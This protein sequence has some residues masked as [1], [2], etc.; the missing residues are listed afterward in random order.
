[1][2]NINDI[3]RILAPIKN[4]IY[5]IIGRAILSAVKN[6]TKTATVQVKGLDG[7]VITDM[8]YMSPYGFEAMPSEGQV[9]CIFINGNRDQGMAILLHNRE[10]RPQD[11][12]TDE[13][14]VWSKYNNFMKLNSAGEV[15]TEASSGAY[16]KEN[17]SGEVE[18]NGNVDYAVR[19]NELKIAFDQLK[20]DF[21]N[22]II[23]V[24]NLHTHQYVPGVVGLAPTAIPVPTDVP[25]TADMSPSK[26]DTVRLP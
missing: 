24:F 8:E 4:K 2:I 19:Y 3:F 18:V 20:A 15:N 7:E 11:L 25:S 22:H 10:E 26:V 17:N 14:K 9:V 16:V 6:D 5:L 13:V 21:D 1:M 23:K 12:S